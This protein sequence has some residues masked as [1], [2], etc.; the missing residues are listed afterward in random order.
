MDDRL[1]NNHWL[2]GGDCGTIADIRLTLAVL[3]LE[4]KVP[5]IMK[6]EHVLDHM[7]TVFDI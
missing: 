2:I 3:D 7:S 5:D 6:Y 4:D 1:V